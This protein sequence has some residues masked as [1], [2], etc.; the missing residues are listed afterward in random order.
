MGV[1]S[2][3]SAQSSSRDPSSPPTVVLLALESM[4]PH[5]VQASFTSVQVMG[6][7]ERADQGA[8]IK[9]T[10]EVGTR[11][12]TTTA[13]SAEVLLDQKSEAGQNPG[14]KNRV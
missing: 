6:G 3:T 14:G 13:E 8:G 5:H 4:W 11:V 9:P 1:E 10:E 2:T 12:G 7:G